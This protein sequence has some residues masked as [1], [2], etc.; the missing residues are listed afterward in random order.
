VLTYFST[1]ERRAF[2]DTVS[3]LS[4][5]W[6]SYEGP[7]VMSSGVYAPLPPSPEPARALFFVAAGGRPVAFAD[8]LGQTM[9]WFG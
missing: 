7:S 8:G 5:H 6:I 9:H 4:A 1:P 2:A 3:K